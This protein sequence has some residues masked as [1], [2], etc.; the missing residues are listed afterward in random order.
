MDLSTA[1]ESSDTPSP[2]PAVIPDLDIKVQNTPAIVKWRNSNGE[3]KRLTAPVA[4]PVGLIIDHDVAKGTA[5]LKLQAAIKMKRSPATSRIFLTIKPSQIR[6]VSCEDD[7]DRSEEEQVHGH[8]ACEELRCRVHSVHI[9][10]NSPPSLT[11]P[12]EHPFQSLRNSSQ[13]IWSDW[14]KFA[15]NTTRFVV[16]FP[17]T[18]ISRERLLRFCDNFSRLASPPDDLGRL[19]GGRGGV[20]VNSAQETADAPPA[21]TEQSANSISRVEPLLALDPSKESRPHFDPTSLTSSAGRE[22]SPRKRRRAPSS[23]DVEVTPEKQQPTPRPEHPQET[24][25][26]RILR[27]LDTQNT[28]LAKILDRVESIEGRLKA[29]ESRDLSDDVQSHMEP[30]LEP[31]WDELDSRIVAS[32]DKTHDYVKDLV[33]DAVNEKVGDIPEF[34]NEYFHEEEGRGLI[35]DAITEAVTETV[36]DVVSERD[37][38]IRRDTMDFLRSRPFTAQFSFNDDG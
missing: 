7:A 21:Y 9:E 24:D 14:N 18:A 37:E 13:D 35:H 30:L 38:R 22:A 33:D 8:D 31:L 3:S 26:Q 28:M 4:A 5:C 34:V 16:Y 2:E 15:K 17:V 27:S 32:E 20:V 10:L 36:A 29:L 12:V 11:A 1:S 19:Y 6:I 25:M 23:S